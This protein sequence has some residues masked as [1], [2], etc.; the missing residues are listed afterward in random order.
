VAVS[1]RFRG[2]QSIGSFPRATESH[3]CLVTQI[4]VTELNIS[5]SWTAVDHIRLDSIV[6]MG[7]RVGD[8]GILICITRLRTVAN[9]MTLWTK[10]LERHNYV[11]SVSA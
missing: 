9:V 4:L 2:E 11:T 3:A 7:E 5:A 1:C 8:V 6:R 10:R